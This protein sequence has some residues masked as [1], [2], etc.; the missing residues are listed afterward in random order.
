MEERRYRIRINLQSG[1]IEVEGD[2]EFVKEEI[3]ILINEVTN[4]FG[5]LSN[6]G[7]MEADE[8]VDT[9]NKHK[10]IKENLPYESFAEFYK[11]ISPEKGLDKI[12]LAAYWLDIKEGMEEIR[13]KDVENLL[14]NA[15]VTPP[16]SIAR[17]MGILAGGQKAV[18]IKLKRGAY[19]VSNTGRE[20]VERLLK[21]ALE[22]DNE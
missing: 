8:K 5:K 14:K 4:I 16:A 7:R 15:R 9:Y 22:K 21:E 20:E 2:K 17:D 6:K 13:P 3:K 18:L 10:S 19:K 1:E 11:I 12:L